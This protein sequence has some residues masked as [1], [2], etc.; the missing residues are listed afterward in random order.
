MSQKNRKKRQE[1]A[2]AKP[3]Q[4][5][6]KFV[7]QSI[8]NFGLEKQ[9]TPSSP[10]LP[11]E[12]PKP[13]KAAPEQPVSLLLTVTD[14]CALLNLSRSTIVRMEKNGTIPGRLKVGGSV[15]YHRE[16]IEKWLHEQAA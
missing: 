7:P 6:A 5:P 8:P 11:V 9:V 1:N 4:V 3:S 15:R 16:I 12:V 13:K 2:L 10:T 14:L